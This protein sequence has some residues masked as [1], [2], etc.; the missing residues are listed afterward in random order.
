MDNASHDADFVLK[1]P[2]F[3]SRI[4][5]FMGVVDDLRQN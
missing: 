2:F 1:K 4:D 3:G 5:S